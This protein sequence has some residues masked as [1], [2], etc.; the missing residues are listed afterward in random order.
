MSHIVTITT[1]IRDGTAL[2]SACRRLQLEPPR[3]QT[4]RLFSREVTGTTVRLPDWRYPVVCHLATGQLDYDNFEGRWGNRA[5]L[6]RLL[7]TYAV[8]KTRIEA[9]RAG[10][11]VTEQ[12]LADGSIR[13]TVS[14]GAS[15]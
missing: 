3:Q 9:R 10:H 8:E 15:A 13:L 6:N 7:Q 2:S 5:H 1:E 4:V 11:S 12:E 14:T